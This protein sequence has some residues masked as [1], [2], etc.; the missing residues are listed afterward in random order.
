MYTTIIVNSERFLV[1]IKCSNIYYENEFIFYYKYV[2]EKSL[3]V[4]DTVTFES[5]HVV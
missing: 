3:K 1:T 5:I 2:V 4:K